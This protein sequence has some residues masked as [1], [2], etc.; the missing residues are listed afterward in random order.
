MRA[1][2]K[3]LTHARFL[4]SPD[5][6]FRAIG[7]QSNISWYGEHR[8]YR[9]LFLEPKYSPFCQ[10][11]RDHW[12]TILFS[13]ETSITADESVDTVGGPN[14]APLTSKSDTAMNALLAMAATTP[15][16]PNP[17]A[18]L[19]ISDKPGP[20]STEDHETARGFKIH[21]LLNDHDS[22]TNSNDSEDNQPAPFPQQF[23]VEISNEGGAKRKRKQDDEAFGPEESTPET[24][25]PKRAPKNKGKA[26]QLGVKK[27]GLSRQASKAA[28]KST[29]TRRRAPK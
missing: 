10:S 13:P 20:N 3:L 19:V 11:I 12:N 16:L 7:K 8:Y 15:E 6:E 23:L 25:R 28:N 2:L 27:G 21:S 24:K 29:G 17:S 22:E 4:V 18:A 5:V 14:V 26:N 9:H 1:V